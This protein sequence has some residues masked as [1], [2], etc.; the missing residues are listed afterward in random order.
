[1][2]SKRKND[3]KQALKIAW[4]STNILLLEVVLGSYLFNPN[5][6]LTNNDA[7]LC[8][9]LLSFPSSVP[10]VGLAAYLIQGYP[11]L[12]SA[13]FDYMIICLVAVIAGYLQWFWFIPKIRKEPEPRIISLHLTDPEIESCPISAINPT[14]RR[15]SS[16]S[17][18]PRA[19]FDKSGHSPLERAIGIKRRQVQPTKS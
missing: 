15:K 13:P 17:N 10:A 3:L 1:M 12:V 14:R 16:R 11:P 4:I 5:Y 6:S 2:T 18:L 19:P 7:I 8:L 9:V